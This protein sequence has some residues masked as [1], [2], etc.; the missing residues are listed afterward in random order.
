MPHHPTQPSP[1]QHLRTETLEEARHLVLV[2]S[3]ETV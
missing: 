1:T 3:L 2:V